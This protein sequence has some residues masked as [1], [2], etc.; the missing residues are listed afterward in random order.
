MQEAYA[1]ELGSIDL[2]IQAPEAGSVQQQIEIMENLIS[3]K[4]DGIAI[5][6]T[7]PEA[8]APYIDQAVDAGIQVVTL[9]LIHPIVREQATWEP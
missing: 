8:L 6:S 2:I 9:T 3:M 1:E 4:V 5:G 7:D